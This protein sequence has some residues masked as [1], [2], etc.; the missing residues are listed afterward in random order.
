MAEIVT[1]TPHTLKL[2][3]W[4]GIFRRQCDAQWLSGEP[5]WSWASFTH[6]V[7][8]C[9]DCHPTLASKLLKTVQEII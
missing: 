6:T 8:Q 3:P 4:N 9:E 2:S 7:Y 5:V 1:A